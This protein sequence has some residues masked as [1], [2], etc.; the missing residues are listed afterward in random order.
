MAGPDSSLSPIP[1]SIATVSV[2]TSTTPL[3]LKLSAISQ[4]GFTGIELSFEDLLNFA[5]LHLLREVEDDDYDALCEAADEA[6]HLCGHYGLQIVVLQ[7]FS[8]FE[9]WPEHSDERMSAFKNAR[10]WIKIMKALGTDM[11]Q[12]GSNDAPSPPLSRSRAQA[13]RDLTGLADMLREEDL[14]LAYETRSWATVSTTWKDG[15]EVVKA[16]DR[17]NFGLCL[18]TFQITAAE[19]ADPTTDSGLHGGIPP[20]ELGKNFGD[21]LYEMSTTIPAEKIYM[22]QISDAWRP[23]QPLSAE[24]NVKDRRLK[25]VWSRNY[26]PLPFEGGYFPL[27]EVVRKVLDTG[28]RSWWSVEVFDGGPDGSEDRETDLESFSKRAFASLTKL[29]QEC[30]QYGK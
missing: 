22:L 16:V 30:N 12:V 23:K 15:W 20:E 21:S 4:A 3:H 11:L 29:R 28:A 17:E 27:I 6:R 18:D 25:S 26:R 24:M 5:T 8:N 14:K 2:G 10:G 7:P 19:Y 13:V 9:G 1:F